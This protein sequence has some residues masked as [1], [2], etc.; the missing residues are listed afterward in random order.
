MDKS[1]LTF[2][3]LCIL[4]IATTFIIYK[5]NATK[6]QA[7]STLTIVTVED[8]STLGESSQDTEITTV[9]K[10]S[11]YKVVTQTTTTNININTTS[12]TTSDT[13]KSITTSTIKTTTTKTKSTTSTKAVT[14]MA[15]EEQDTQPDF[16]ISLNYITSEEL[17]AING[18]GESTAQKIID[19]RNALGGFT[20]RYQLLEINGIG[21]SKMNLIMEYTYIE[22]EDLTYGQEDSQEVQ[23]QN[24]NL[25]DAYD[26]VQYGNIEEEQSPATTVTENPYPIELNTATFETLLLIPNMTEELA[27][28]ILEL[29]DTIGYFS[30]TYELLYVDGIGD[31]Y[32]NEI[33]PYII[34]E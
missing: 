2:L 26:I 34:V 25:A 12:A 33:S 7:Q 24:Q 3:I 9:T 6:Y 22:N 5:Y 10:G 28:N 13:S 19:Y 14:S 20:S 4:V 29:R 31:T 15:T 1:N 21:E 23:D 8:T 17:Q 32:L 11:T 18:I 16:P 27:Q 30:S